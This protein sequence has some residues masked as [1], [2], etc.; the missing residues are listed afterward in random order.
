MFSGPDFLYANAFFPEAKTYLLSGLE[1]V[2]AIPN[3]TERTVE[4]LPRIQQSIGTSLRLSF[5]ITRQMRDQ[6]AGG[7]LAGTLPIL[8]VYIARSGKDDPRGQCWSVSTGTAICIRAWVRP[9]A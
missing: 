1:P 9:A 6:L 4:S 8:Y 7:D 2:G 3:I 5:F